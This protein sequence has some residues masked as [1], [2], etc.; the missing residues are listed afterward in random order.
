MNPN[1]EVF[2]LINNNMSNPFF[3]VLLPN[4]TNLGGFACLSIICL[5]ALILSYKNIFN[6]RKFYTLVKLCCASLLITTAIVLVLKLAFTQ[7]RPYL[8][9]DN[10]NV[11]AASLDPNSFPSGHTSSTLSIVTVLLLKSKEYFERYKLIDCLLII[12]ALLIA[13]SRIYIG[14]HYPFDVLV[15]GVIG[16]IVGVLVSRYLEI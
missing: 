10:V 3:D 8:V 9:L 13:V 12:F 15:G 14:M 11:L 5:I 7:P 1:V 4:L 6:L 2:Y 16:M